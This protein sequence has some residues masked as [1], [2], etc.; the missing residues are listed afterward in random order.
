L[1]SSNF[2]LS[3]PLCLIGNL[4]LIV[5]IARAIFSWFP[6]SEGSPFI[7]LVRFLRAVTEPVLA[8]LRRIIPPAGMF[9]ISFLVLFLVIELVVLPLLCRV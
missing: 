3:H 4:Y 8:P 6:L 2:N 1:F 7:P 5:L 9:D